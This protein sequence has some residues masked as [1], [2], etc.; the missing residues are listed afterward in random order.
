MKLTT[1]QKIAEHR[2]RL[3]LSQEALG[4]KMGVSRQAISKWEADS[5]LP[6][7]EK[8]IGL[9]RL[10]EVN[11]GW[12]LGVEELHN[13]QE[14]SAEVSEA[15]LR[16]IEE[17][18]LR[19]R[20]KEKKLSTGM[21]IAIGIAAAVILFFGFRFYSQWQIVGSTV[22]YLS[23]QVRN[24][25][26][27]NARILEQLDG[28]EEQISA[29]SESAI[30]LTSYTFDVEPHE[31]ENAVMLHFHAVPDQ[32][33]KDYKAF[34]VVEFEKKEYV[35]QQCVWSSSG[36]RSA[37][38]MEVQDGYSYYLLAEFPDGSMV[39]IPLENE[40]AENLKTAFTVGITMHSGYA[41]FILY[42][43]TAQLHD[44]DMTLHFPGSMIQCDTP[45]ALASTT[46]ILYGCTWE[47]YFQSWTQLGMT[48]TYHDKDYMIENGIS[49]DHYPVSYP[50]NDQFILTIKLDE[51]DAPKMDFFRLVIRIEMSNGMTTEHTLNEWHRANGRSTEIFSLRE[52]EQGQNSGAE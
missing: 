6:E 27:Q 33:H 45:I 15:L 21:R 19:Y 5:T 42:E 10:F 11:V 22:G 44:Y 8:L 31:T 46:Y 2:K 38:K 43:K 51:E 52:N 23:G 29:K 14:Q 39:Q 4:E 20:P 41:D 12:L 24:N 30:S 7:I 18:V 32:W 37:L 9:S 3:G 48:T 13:P 40:P 36:L 25:N 34:L 49:F 26:E 17:T 16:K 47:N 1:G 35:K 50:D 28:L